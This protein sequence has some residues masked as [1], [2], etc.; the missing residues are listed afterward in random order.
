MAKLLDRTF[1]RDLYVRV[2]TLMVNL[3][4]GGEHVQEIAAM[5][6]SKYAQEQA[7]AARALAEATNLPNVRTRYLDAAAAW[8]Q[9]AARAAHTESLREMPLGSNW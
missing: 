4:P 9:F 3:P 1:L 8:S 6:D 5:F 2:S 7:A